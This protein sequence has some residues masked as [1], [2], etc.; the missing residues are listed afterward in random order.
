MDIRGYEYEVVVQG[1]ILNHFLS[2]YTDTLELRG[3]QG[4]HSPGKRKSLH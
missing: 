1:N 2:F 3:S 4:F